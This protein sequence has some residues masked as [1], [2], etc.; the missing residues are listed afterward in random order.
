MPLCTAS[1]T[2]EERQARRS[3]LL[4][5]RNGSLSRPAGEGSDKNLLYRG[6]TFARGVYYA[7]VHSEKLGRFVFDFH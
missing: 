7:T 6:V 5:C 4:K 3:V 2:S 1:I